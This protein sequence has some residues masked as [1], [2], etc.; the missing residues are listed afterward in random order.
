M[1]QAP[2]AHDSEDSEDRALAYVLHTMNDAERRTFETW[3][4]SADEEHR[5]E[6][7]RLQALV[8]DLALSVSPRIP[9]ARVKES[10]MRSIRAD[11][12]GKAADSAAATQ[13]W[14]RWVG[15]SSSGRL[16]VRGS[17]GEWEA[18]DVPGVAVRRLAV[19]SDRDV[20][21]MMIRMEPGSRYPSHRH[22]GV[23]E[24]YVLDG[25]L[26]HGDSVMLAGDFE[27]LESRT[28]HGEQWTENGCLLLIHSSQHDELTT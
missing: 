7:W 22:G 11:R 14:K 16:L 23:E 2:P 4:D 12:E 19:D 3:L 13:V 27:R 26:R 21:T 24:C 17:E 15:T 8:A 18:T 28:L 10:L 1:D 5:R 20:V 6:V 25:D 9:P